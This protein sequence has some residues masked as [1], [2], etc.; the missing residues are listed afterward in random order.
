MGKVPLTPRMSCVDVGG[1]LAVQR[2]WYWWTRSDYALLHDERARDEVTWGSWAVRL[3]TNHA[4][5]RPGFQTELLL[6]W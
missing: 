4:T 2:E 6:E 3:G 1:Y 5:M